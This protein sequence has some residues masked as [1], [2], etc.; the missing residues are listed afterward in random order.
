M[1]KISDEIAELGCGAIGFLVAAIILGVG[2][3]IGWNLI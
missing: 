3:K 2:L 1:S